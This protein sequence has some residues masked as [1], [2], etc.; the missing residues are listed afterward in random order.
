M[1][2]MLKT[3]A[4]WLC[5]IVLPA[6][7]AARAARAQDPA[8]KAA[9][10]EGQ[11]AARKATKK[12]NPVFPEVAKLARLKGTVKLELTVTP[13]GAVKSVKTLG[14]NAVFIPAAEEAVKKWKFETAK[15]ESVETVSVGF[16]TGD[17][18]KP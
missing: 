5:L 9:P 16:G 13:D 17:E 10:T 7:I 4:F 15:E 8:P 6:G 14:G 18:S 12:V 3:S 11:D 1:T 2:K